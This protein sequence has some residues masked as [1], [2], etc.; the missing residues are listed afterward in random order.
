MEMLIINL[1][2]TNSWLH[3][4]ISADSLIGIL[5]I[6]QEDKRCAS[7]C[8]CPVARAPK[9]QYYRSRQHILPTD[10]I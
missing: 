6:G 7:A 4:V 1:Y 5:Q 10:N 8:I 9:C 2:E 3:R